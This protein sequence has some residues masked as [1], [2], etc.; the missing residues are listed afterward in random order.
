MNSGHFQ[1]CVCKTGYEDK[2]NGECVT[3]CAQTTS[4]TKQGT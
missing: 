3:A 2:S 1:E 4:S